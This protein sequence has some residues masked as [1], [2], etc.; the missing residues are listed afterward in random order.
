MSL[1][2][3]KCFKTLFRGLYQKG[4]LISVSKVD[5]KVREGEICSEFIPVDGKA[6]ELQI[7][8]VKS[9]L[10]S[11]CKD[12]TCQD[13]IFISSLIDYSKQVSEIVLPY[14]LQVPELPKAEV[15]WNYGIKEFTQTIEIDSETLRPMQ[16]G[17]RS[18]F[19]IDEKDLFKGCKYFGEFVLKYKKRPNRE[20]LAVFYYNRYVEAGK[21]ST[22]PFLT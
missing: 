3:R 22:L 1:R 15:N 19:G 16:P 4:F 5:Q 20:E 9:R 6:D 14:T 2:Q 17:G 10:P 7:Q 8:A 11:F 18:L 21:R 13:L 12:M